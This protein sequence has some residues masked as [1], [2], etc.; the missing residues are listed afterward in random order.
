ML[1]KANDP[2][3]NVIARR[4]LRYLL[5]GSSAH[6]NED[7]ET[8]WLL[9]HGQHRAWSKLWRQLHGAHA[10]TLI[11]D[12]LAKRD[13]PIRRQVAGVK[14]LDADNLIAEL[15]TPGCRLSTPSEFN[16][17]EREEILLRI[18]DE[19][20]WRR[21]PLHTRLDDENQPIS[22]DQSSVYLAPDTGIPKDPLFDNAIFVVRARDP[23][24]RQQQDSWLKPIAHKLR[25]LRS[26]QATLLSADPH[27]NH[28]PRPCPC[29]C[30]RCR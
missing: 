18:E 5:H 2:G 7:Q 9:R 1:E 17:E 29:P 25:F 10:W 13:L 24:V 20:V 22:A 14:D 15:Q 21:L 12:E 28:R 4:G 30:P 19:Q 23:R 16:R 3:G 11:P 6:R 8:L 26:C 27:G